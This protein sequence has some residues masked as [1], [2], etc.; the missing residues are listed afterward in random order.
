VPQLA[1]DE[2]D[3]DVVLPTLGYAFLWVTSST[4]TVPVRTCASALAC[5]ALAAATSCTRR[6]VPEMLG[7]SRAR[8]SP[9]RCATAAPSRARSSI[10]FA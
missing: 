6:A 1:E 10:S 9:L 3:G 5:S 8:A 4:C 7:S 2:V